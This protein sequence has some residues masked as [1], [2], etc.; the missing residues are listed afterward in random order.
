MGCQW[1]INFTSFGRKEVFAAGYLMD[2]SHLSDL[3]TGEIS[4]FLKQNASHSA[5]KKCWIII[6]NVGLITQHQKLVGG[7]NHLERYESQWEG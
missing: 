1:H 2:L 7:F 5:I 6:K 3:V 4:G